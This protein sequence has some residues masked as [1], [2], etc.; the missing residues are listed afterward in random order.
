MRLRWE[1][2]EYFFKNLVAGK[3][4]EYIVDRYLYGT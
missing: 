2:E 4:K 1:C 3:K